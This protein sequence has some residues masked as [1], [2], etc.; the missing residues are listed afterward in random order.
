M[1]QKIVVE[2]VYKIFGSKP[3]EAKQMIAEG[4]SKNEIFAQDRKSVV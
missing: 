1:T 3:D 2:D 4:K